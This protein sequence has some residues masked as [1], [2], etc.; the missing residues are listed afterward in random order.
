MNLK[1]EWRY[2]G[3]LLMIERE[4][5]WRPCRDV[6]STTFHNNKQH[7][8]LSRVYETGYTPIHGMIHSFILISSPL[9]LLMGWF[10]VVPPSHETS[11]S[12]FLAMNDDVI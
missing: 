8:K 3:D 6:G 10:I 1:H 5:Q 2:D 4:I 12:L 11:S 7:P 9:L